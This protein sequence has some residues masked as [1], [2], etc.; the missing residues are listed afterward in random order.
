RSPDP[1]QA[2][3]SRGARLLPAVTR[4]TPRVA[5]GAWHDRPGDVAPPRLCFGTMRIRRLLFFGLLACWF[6]LS[7]GEKERASPAQA[8]A[9]VAV[10]AVENEDVASR[11][12]RE[13]GGRHPVLWLGLDGL[14]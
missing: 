3:R 11:T 10:Q 5:T 7:C 6:V 9:P 14:D 1:A 8:T 12:R 13:A 4:E 2:L